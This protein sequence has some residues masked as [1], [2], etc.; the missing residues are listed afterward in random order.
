MSSSWVGIFGEISNVLQFG[1]KPNIRI[2][3][4]FAKPTRHCLQL[5]C[6][7]S[8]LHSPSQNELSNYN[9]CLSLRDLALVMPLIFLVSETGHLPSLY[10]TFLI[11]RQRINATDL[12]FYKFWDVQR[13]ARHSSFL[14]IPRDVA[15]QMECSLRARLAKNVV[16]RKQKLKKIIRVDQKQR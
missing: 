3:K 13:R 5:L 6:C 9:Y 7:Y 15:V 1:R 12:L 2:L 16:S 14:S 8:G 10:F 4:S 11:Y